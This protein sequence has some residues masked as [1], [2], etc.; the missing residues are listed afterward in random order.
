MQSLRDYLTDV[1]ADPN[2]LGEDAPD[3]YRFYLKLNGLST[4]IDLDFNTSLGD[5][6]EL[7]GGFD[8]NLF[9]EGSIGFAFDANAPDLGSSFL[10]DTEA[11]VDQDLSSR[12][13]ADMAR[14][15]GSST[16]GSPELVVGATLQSTEPLRGRLGF[17]E[18]EATSASANAALAGVRAG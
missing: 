12:M 2:R 7:S 1:R 10:L 5:I 3:Y 4:T 8:L 13:P 14:L 11:G 17:L 16:D 9:A 15:F 18:L 6:L